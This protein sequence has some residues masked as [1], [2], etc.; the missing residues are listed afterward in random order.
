MDL[1]SLPQVERPRVLLAEVASKM[2]GT[3][4]PDLTPNVTDACR[5]TDPDTGALVAAYYPLEP[6]HRADLRRAVLGIDMSETY[7]SASGRRNA[8]RVFGMSPRKSF[9]RRESCRPTAL[10]ADQPEQHA[11]LVGLASILAHD[12]WEFA[13]AVAERDTATLGPVLDEWRMSESSL[14]TSGVVNKSSTLPYHRDGFNFPVWSAMPVLRRGMDGGAL[15]IAEYDL[16]VGCR[17][18]WVVYFPGWEL[19]HGV[20]PMRPTSRDAYRF[21]VV[22]YA[23]KGMKDCHTYAVETAEGGKRRTA[24]EEGIA[25]SATGRAP[26][27]I[28]P[29]P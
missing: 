9:Q 20:T 28:G 1:S 8:S 29:R 25:A 4:T 18:G 17:D 15:H 21:S 2:V 27:R 16:V 23:L 24:R 6:D 26:A 7:R 11:V 19:L 14:W 10:A 13:P 22:Y 3:S 5:V 12:L